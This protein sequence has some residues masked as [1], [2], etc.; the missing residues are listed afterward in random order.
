[1]RI[2]PLGATDQVTGSRTLVSDG[3]SSLLV[4]CGLFQGI[5]KTRSLNWGPFPVPPKSLPAVILTHA[6]LDHSGYVPA[7]IR[8]GFSGPVWCT[9]GTADLLSLLWPDAGYLAEEDARYRNRH[10]TTR[11]NPALPLFTADEGRAALR[12]LRTVEF[13][14]EFEP[15]E[16]LRARF[17]R[18]GHILGAASLHLAN[19]RCSVGFSGDVGRPHDPLMFA[20][21][22]LPK[23]DLV[24]VESTYGDRLHHDTPPEE[25]LGE[26][27]RRTAERGGVLLIPSFAVGR[28]QTLLHLLTRLRSEGAIPR[29]PTYLNSPMAIRATRIFVD[30]VGEHRLDEAACRDLME[31]VE[32]T[33]D[34][35]DSRALNRLSGPAI[36]ISASGMATGG[37]ILHHLKAFLPDRNNTVLFVGFQAAGTRGEAM[38]SGVDEVKIHGAYHPVRAEVAR[39]DS[40]S[41]HA[42]RDELL[43]WLE[44]MPAAPKLALVNHGEPGPQD[45]FRRAIQDAL[46][47]RAAVAESGEAIEVEQLEARQGVS[48]W[49]RRSSR[50]ARMSAGSSGPSGPANSTTR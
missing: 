37:R 23:S 4:D 45:A 50:S 49:S 22:P 10:K 11:H 21:E 7:L 34:V 30:H 14:R 8:N 18:A 48:T 15:V 28:A 25:A 19:D 5:K 1:M 13:G 44:A 40:L 9:A 31:G 39:I 38:V 33:P 16:G 6:H 29:I 32:F 36:I 47:W 20:P 41:A 17:S 35:S 43:D 46:G 2:T 27:V 12:R 42:D 26:I 24:I 3:P